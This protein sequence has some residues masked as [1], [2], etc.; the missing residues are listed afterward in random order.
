MICPTG[1]FPCLGTS[2]GSGCLQRS[3]AAG[4]ATVCKEILMSKKLMNLGLSRFDELKVDE[5]LGLAKR[6]GNLF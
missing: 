1:G 5:T 4:L 2:V 6:Y 3:S